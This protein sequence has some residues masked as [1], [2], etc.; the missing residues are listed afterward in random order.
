MP[1]TMPAAHQSKHAYRL[2]GV[3]QVVL[4]VDAHAQL[5]HSV[6]NG[7]II[8][9]DDPSQIGAPPGM[10]CE[11][12]SDQLAHNFN[13]SREYTETNGINGFDTNNV[14]MAQNA[15]SKRL[16]LPQGGDAI[17]TETKDGSVSRRRFVK[18]R[19]QS[20]PS[21]I[22]SFGAAFESHVYGTS[23]WRHS[24]CKCL[25][26]AAPNMTIQYRIEFI[27]LKARELTTQS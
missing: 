24:G 7:T 5:E 3:R 10:H 13:G 11:G 6:V 8:N 14:P 4:F 19:R 2:D 27:A 21:T 12:G 22:G 1:A 25:P 15:G 20:H 17:V 9:G 18:R 16:V 26:L 23:S